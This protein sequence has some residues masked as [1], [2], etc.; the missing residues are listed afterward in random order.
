MFHEGHMN[1]LVIRNYLFIF[2]LPP[3]IV[4]VVDISLL[5]VFLFRWVTST[6]TINKV[7]IVL[8]CRGEVS[9]DD[10]SF[11]GITV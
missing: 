5:I 7:R 9:G 11:I 3:C 10:I 8:S 6:V 2:E 1:I 4:I